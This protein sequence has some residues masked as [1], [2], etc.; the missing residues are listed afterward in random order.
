M[1]SRQ[2]TGLFDHT[3]KHAMDWSLG[4]VVNSAIY[5]AETV[6]YGYGIH[7]SPRTYGHSGQQTS[8][9]FAD[10]DSDLAVALIVNGM[11]GP[12]KHHQRFL[13]LLNALYE[14]LQLFVES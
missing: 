1:V 11:P 8:V 9:A 12:D 3:F 4:F 5:G 13:H 7:A 6:P 10:P 14:D 2:R